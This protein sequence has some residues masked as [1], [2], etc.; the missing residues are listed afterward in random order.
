PALRAF[1]RARVAP[2]FHAEPGR[3]ARASRRPRAETIAPRFRARAGRRRTPA[4]PSGAADP[5]MPESTG[6]TQ[7][8][9]RSGDGP[10]TLPPKASGLAPA[11]GPRILD[12]PVE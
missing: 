6:G 5:T 11:L 8:R 9:A 7:A 2:R 10:M 1:V 3:V 12:P 4:K